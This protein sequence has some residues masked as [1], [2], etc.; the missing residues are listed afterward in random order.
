MR[1][2]AH[3]FCWLFW[4]L[5]GLPAVPAATVDWLYEVDVPVTDQSPDARSAAFKSALSTVLKRISGLADV[6]P[7]SAITAALAAPQRYYVQYRYRTEDN[8][9]P[10]ALPSKT[11]L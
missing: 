9:S 10:G 4:L 11:L 6:P 5:T 2:F 7:N 1:R 3:V 8:P